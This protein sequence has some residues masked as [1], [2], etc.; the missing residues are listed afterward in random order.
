[1]EW[2]IILAPLLLKLFE[3][4]QETNNADRAK[5]IKRNGPL[6]QLRILRALRSQGMGRAERQRKARQIVTDIEMASVQDVE[7]FLDE[8]DDE[9]K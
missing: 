6:V 1:M 8:L 3:N 5:V 2:V 9:E 4:C 7:D